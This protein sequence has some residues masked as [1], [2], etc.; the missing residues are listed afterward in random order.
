MCVV[1]D[2]Q[3][4]NTYS[5][6]HVNGMR[7]NH[8]LQPFFKLLL[9][10]SCNNEFPLQGNKYIRLLISVRSKCGVLVSQDT[11]TCLDT[12]F[13]QPLLPIEC[14]HSPLHLTDSFSFLFFFFFWEGRAGFSF[15]LAVTFMQ[16][17]LFL[18]VLEQKPYM[19]PLI[20]I[21]NN[22]IAPTTLFFRINTQSHS[23]ITPS[24]SHLELHILTWATDR[25]DTCRRTKMCRCCRI[26]SIPELAMI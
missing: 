2:S 3:C 14:I 7:D 20:T 15:S 12:P 1:N 4:R 17:K 9:W 6:F 23:V 8:I 19:Y 10:Y 26:L 11:S 21:L 16:S 25:E 22:S 18:P 13:S 5:T 24:V